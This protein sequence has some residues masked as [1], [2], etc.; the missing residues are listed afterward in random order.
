M[1]GPLVGVALEIS[2]LEELTGRS[3]PTV[4]TWFCKNKK[5]KNRYEEIVEYSYKGKMNLWIY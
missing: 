4:I 5:K 2:K 3:S 1:L